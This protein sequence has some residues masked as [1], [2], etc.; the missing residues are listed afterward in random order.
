MDASP[1]LSRQL[2]KTLW[3]GYSPDLSD[4][5]AIERFT[6]RYGQ[7][8]KEVIRG[9]SVVLA[10]PVIAY[11]DPNAPTGLESAV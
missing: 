3:Y 6:A 2:G 11:D 9:A 8:P 5:Q 1:P 7:A 10:G 4:A